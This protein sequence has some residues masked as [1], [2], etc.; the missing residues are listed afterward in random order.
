MLYEVITSTVR[1]IYLYDSLYYIYDDSFINCSN[2]TTLRINAATKPVYSGTYFDA[3]TDR[4]DWLLSIGDR[5]K[6]VMFSGSSSRYGYR[7]NFV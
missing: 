2:L 3:F 7:N 6:I 1:E 4:Y 5:R